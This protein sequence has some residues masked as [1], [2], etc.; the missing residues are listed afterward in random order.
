MNVAPHTA[1]LITLI[2]DSGYEKVAEV[3]CLQGTTADAIRL[4]CPTVKRYYM[5]D[6]WAVYAGE[7]SGKAARITQ[8]RW[9]AIHDE[10]VT[11]FANDRRFEI[12]RKPSL[13]AVKLFKA[14]SLDIVFIDAIHTH[15]AVKKD[16]KAWMSIVRLGGI[17]CGDDYVSKYP[18]VK[19]AVNEMIPARLELYGKDRVW[20]Y[21]RIRP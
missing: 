7:G 2:N 18:G 14:L 12:I 20:A 9:D 15:E 21:R 5:I 19:Q 3:G 1:V 4:H 10:I 6:P 13:E 8:E 16:I 17:L 11:R